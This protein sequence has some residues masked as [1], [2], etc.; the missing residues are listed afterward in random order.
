MS[1]ERVE[2]VQVF[3]QNRSSNNNTYSYENG[4]PLLIFRIAAD[5]KYLM[6]SSLRL[7]FKL[8]LRT[9]TGGLPENQYGTEVRLDPKIGAASLFSE[10]EISNSRNDTLE[11]VRYAPRLAASI[12][13]STSGWGDYC[14]KLQQSFAATSNSAASGRMQNREQQCSMP[15]LAAMF[16]SNSDTMGKLPMS[17]DHI[18]GLRIVLRLSPSI[19]SNYGTVGG[20]ANGSYYE[21]SNVSLTYNAGI[22]EGGMIPKMK[23]IPLTSYSS[24]YNVLN[25]SD[26]T[27][28]I[29]TAL[30][31]VLSTTSNFVPTEHISS[32]SHNENLTNRLLNKNAAGAYS[33]TAPILDYDSLVGGLK[34]P[35]NFTQSSIRNVVENANG[36]YTNSIYEAQRERYYL[37]SLSSYNNIKDTLAGGISE[38]LQSTP[39]DGNFNDRDANVFGVGARFNGALTSNGE[40]LKNRPF[41]HRIRSQLNGSSPNSIYTYMLHRSVLV[42]GGNGTATTIE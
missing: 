24:Y 18:N 3:P 19:N 7:N 36:T 14:T 29:P 40:N 28:T 17:P 37:N 6:T 15:I 8:Q 11:L 21:L 34:R 12:L 33:D 32:F 42:L 2:K 26:E 23:S 38:G 39:D 22:P 25:N 10:I 20:S 13:G 41:T 9:S 5:E 27:L 4:N 30:G 16:M 35:Y 31:Q 1:I